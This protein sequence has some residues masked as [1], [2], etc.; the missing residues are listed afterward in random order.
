MLLL[1]VLGR[2]LNK[3]VTWKLLNA[4]PHSNSHCLTSAANISSPTV[5]HYSKELCPPGSGPKKH[6]G[7]D[8]G[9]GG[10]F[11]LTL[12]ALTL[13]GGATLAYAKYD[14]DFRNTLV[15]YA[16]FTESI[17]DSM[18]GLSP[19]TLYDDAKK[20]IL[21]GFGG[22]Q[23]NL[24]GGQDAIP[25]PKEYKAPPPILPII[26]KEIPSKPE[27]SYKEIRVEEKDKD[28]DIGEPKPKEQLSA[29]NT[30]ALAELEQKICRSAEDAVNAYNKAVHVLLSY[31]RDIE[32]II[33]EA[34]NE[35]K[36][37]YWETIREK[38]RHKDECIRRAQAK[39][40]EATRDIN[41]LKALVSSSDFDAPEN[42]KV[43]IKNN[44]SKVQDDIN[45]AKHEME[46]ELKHGNVTEKYWDKVERARKNFSE[47]LEIL[48]PNVDISKK[49]LQINA[50]ELDLFILHAYAN[51]LF[52]QKELAK[53]ETLLQSRVDQAV[54][55]AKRGGLEPL[56]LAQICE[57]VEQEKRRLTACFQ[58]Q[59]LKLRKEAEQE[60]REQLKRQ[61][62]C[63]NDHLNEAI[64]V[65]EMEIERALSRRFDE[66]LERE[67]CLFKIQ[68]AAMVGRLKGL[69]E[70][71]KARN[72]A[73][74]SSKQAQVLWSACQSLLR[75]IR[76]GCPGIPWKDQIRP[77][78]PEIN[79]VVK[80]AA[81]NDE[82]V[83]IVIETM[84]R[85]AKERGVF[86]E[87]ALRERF[88]KVEKVARTVD[89]VPAQ[90]AALPVHVL[91]YIQSVLLIKS[92]SPIPQAELNDEKVDFSKLN[93]NEILQRARYWLDRGDFAQALKYM[94]LLKGAPRCVAKQWMNETRILLETQ[95]AANT[96][97]AHAASSGLMYL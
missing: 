79:A 30:K 67:R 29:T 38:T 7:G 1:K 86:P 61:S 82:L 11:L 62:Q 80:A 43:I 18:D 58:Q 83:S 78:E 9:G 70:G 52:Y 97:M 89:L 69:D 77:L 17:L 32:Y 95:Q 34:V 13:A 60:L 48:F 72:D 27:E 75:A 3:R 22:N 8:G 87:D 73:D 36:P 92:P 53:M 4:P 74:A 33:D 25:E 50:E 44:I 56:T 35:V 59:V 42:T 16:P 65:K 57:A 96:L 20:S 21:S 12:G 54:E 88:L 81:E 37:E 49:K 90:G 28:V 24:P 19:G 15:S 2:L 23:K 46:L 84:P 68:L 55:E 45:A 64:R 31:N 91:S 40:E 51:V 93:T 63:F 71:I 66:M 14:K 41:K 6:E 47:E 26:E 76:A 94:N 10:K 39:A 5:R 85:E